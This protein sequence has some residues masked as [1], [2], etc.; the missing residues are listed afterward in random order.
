MAD[1]TG[2]WPVSQFPG[3]MSRLNLIALF[4]NGGPH[5]ASLVTEPGFADVAV[6]RAHFAR[7]LQLETDCSDVHEST[8]HG[9]DFIL[10]DVRAPALFAAG[11]VPGAINI[12]HRVITAERMA[13]YPQDT[14][15]VVYCAGPHCN[16][17]NK[18][19]IRLTD[20]GFRVKEMIGGITGW[21]DEGFPLESAAAAA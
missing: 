1:V 9:A 18:A 19:A 13:E 7:R 2:V 21:R 17:A 20:L 6:A 11:H 10:I 5:M 4:A 15:C 16:G 3:V 14:P 12:P 8:K